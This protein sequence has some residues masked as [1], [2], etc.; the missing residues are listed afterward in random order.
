VKRRLAATATTTTIS[1]CAAARRGLL[2][3][4]YA[5]CAWVGRIRINA[6]HT[7]TTSTLQSEK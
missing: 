5:A 6:T 4:I 7:T 1:A 3:A 2:T